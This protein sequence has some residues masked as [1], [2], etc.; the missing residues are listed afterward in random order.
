[1][2]EVIKKA[3]DSDDLIVRVYEY[4]NKR[5]N[6]TLSFFKEIEKAYECNLMEENIE[7]VKANGKEISFEIKPY[8]IKT[9]K[10]KLK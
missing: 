2:I 5:T 10:V 1:M 3:E 4:H 9:F 7:E 6:A 8:E